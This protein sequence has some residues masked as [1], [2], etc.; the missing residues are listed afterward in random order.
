MQ[1]KKFNVTHDHRTTKM[2]V[3]HDR[4]KSLNRRDVN[5]PLHNLS[6]DAIDGDKSKSTT[7]TEKLKHRGTPRR[8][9]DFRM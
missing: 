8:F 5:E 6:D 1:L 2:E 4:A 3:K 7:E 9:E